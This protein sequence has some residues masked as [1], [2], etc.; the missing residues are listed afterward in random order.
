MHESMEMRDADPVLKE[1]GLGVIHIVVAL[2]T[3]VKMFP[4]DLEV[5]NIVDKLLEAARRL[6]LE[7]SDP[8]NI[9][10]TRCR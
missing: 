5:N 8:V 1:R 2:E 6:Y 7:A 3:L 10:V 4:D 9:N